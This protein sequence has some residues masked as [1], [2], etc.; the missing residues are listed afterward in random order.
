[1]VSPPNHANK[2]L[3]AVMMKIIVSGK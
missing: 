2:R 3:I 1:V